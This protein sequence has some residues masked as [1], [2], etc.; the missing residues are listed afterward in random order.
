MLNLNW[1][2]LTSPE[3]DWTQMS[4]L[5]RDFK[6]PRKKLHDLLRSGKL[7]RVK[8]GIYVPGEGLPHLP[9]PSSLRLANLVYGPSYVSL[10]SALSFHGLI[11]EATH[12]VTSITTGRNKLF[13]TSIG[14]FSYR[15]HEVNRYSVGVTIAYNHNNTPFLIA[16]PE[17]AIID[18]IWFLRTKLDRKK[19]HSFLID[20]M[21]IEE[22]QLKRLSQGMLAS[23]VPSFPHPCIK[24]FY[25]II[26]ELQ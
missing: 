9:K 11:P 7:I 1:Q 22:E 13:L 15:H 8:N 6:S 2:S 25:Q 24:S 5:L 4:D 10:E 12:E 17:K 3:I 18:C 19:I 21:R 14:S 26:K 23:I 16:T 20:D